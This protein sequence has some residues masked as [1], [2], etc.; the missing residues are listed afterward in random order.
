MASSSE[1]TQSGQSNVSEGKVFEDV[2]EFEEGEDEKEEDE[3]DEEVEQP[4]VTIES[5]MESDRVK[6]DTLFRR[7][8]TERI[9]IRVHDVI[10]KGNKKTKEVLIEAEVEVLKTASTF[11]ELLRAASTVNARL[12]QLD[13]FESVNVTLDAG[14]PELPGTA[15]VV[16]EVVETPR[17]L[18]GDFGIYSRPEARTWSL[19]GSLK[20]KNLFGY[21][22]IWDS[23]LAYGWD[24]TTELSTGVSLPWVK[25]LITPLTA[26]LC[27]LSQDWLKFSSYKE[28]ALGFSLGLLSSR[29]H[30]L[31]YN[32]SWRT[33]S[34]PSQLSSRTVRRQLGHGLL[35]DLKYS[36]KI[37]QRNSPLRPTRGYAFVSTS[38]IG[39][40]F[41][42]YRSLRFLRQE[43][44]IR[45]ALPLGFCNAALNFGLSGGIVFPWGKGFLN[46][47]CYLPERF[48]L[49]G[50]SSPVCTLG[51]PTSVLGFKS[52]GLGPAEPRRQV[53][54]NSNDGSADA[55][56]GLDFVGGDLAVTG[57]A[58]LSFDLPLKVLRD[59]GIHGHVFA[60]T[61]NLSSLTEDSYKNFSLK[62]Y[63]NSFRSSAG[64]GVVVPT[65]LFRM[66][67]NYCYVLKKQEQ[68]QG[69]TGVQFSFSSPL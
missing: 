67:V 22:D 54:E 29:N 1:N 46:M 15:N 18:T 36:F 35:S 52:R 16:V 41:P 47:P 62:G 43:L 5:R 9:P 66:E 7:L 26:R 31:S 56:P 49:G 28:R 6:M 21:G 34:D 59:A 63:L 24:Q 39:G 64:L 55:S 45:Y 40:L 19:E 23:S 60:S 11:Q 32:L 69:K 17:P 14:P 68:D 25:G 42:D 10:I 44:D 57:F 33:L 51:G 4:P 2:D 61:G 50:N 3:D 27:L 20:L 48:F 37:D 53:H 38:R 30:D 65:K 58:D 13:I 8:S 12:Q